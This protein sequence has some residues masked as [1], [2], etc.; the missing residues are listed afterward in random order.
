MGDIIFAP[1]VSVPET[2][3]DK[4]TSMIFSQYDVRTA[5]QTGMVQAVSESVG[6]QILSDYHFRLGVG[7]VY[8]SHD[9]M[10][11][12]F[13]KDIHRWGL[14]IVLVGDYNSFNYLTFAVS[15]YFVCIFRKCAK[16]IV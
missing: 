12:F 11:L 10:P 14:L 6:E 8:G 5:R 15:I 13:G 7:R 2:T 4:D 16:V 3:V 1:F 9:F